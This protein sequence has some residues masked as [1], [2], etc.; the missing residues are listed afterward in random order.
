MLSLDTNHVPSFSRQPNTEK[1]ERWR[2]KICIPGTG[3]G[4]VVLGVRVP[5]VRVTH[6]S[7]IAS[8]QLPKMES[9]C[10]A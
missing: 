6:R 1:S 4:A 5:D 2:R 8:F 10:R 3:T 9:R 7:P